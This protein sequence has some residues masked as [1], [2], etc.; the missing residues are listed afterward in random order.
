MCIMFETENNRSKIKI[1]NIHKM[2]VHTRE[3]RS[4]WFYDCLM[5]VNNLFQICAVAVHTVVDPV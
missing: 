3:K 4:T 1:I 5:Y 2:V